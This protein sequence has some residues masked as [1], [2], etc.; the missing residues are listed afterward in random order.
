MAGWQ[1]RSNACLCMLEGPL[2][3]SL[4]CELT[5]CLRG[6]GLLFCTNKEGVSLCGLCCVSSAARW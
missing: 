6:K 4:V 5:G 3:G 2:L 1:A